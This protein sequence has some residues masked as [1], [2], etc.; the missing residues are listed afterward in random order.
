MLAFCVDA[1]VVV[2]RPFNGDVP[3]AVR[4]RGDPLLHLAEIQPAVFSV[5]IHKCQGKV[6]GRRTAKSQPIAAPKLQG[7]L[8]VSFENGFP[9]VL[10]VLLEKPRHVEL[11]GYA[12]LLGDLAG[13]GEIAGR[14]RVQH[15]L[16]LQNG[17]VLACKREA[18][19]LLG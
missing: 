17:Q 4:Q 7:G 6:C 3:P 15:L 14:T 8:S 19:T 10:H 13:D 1:D 2:S 12:G 18:N 5:H 11:R 16:L 9:F